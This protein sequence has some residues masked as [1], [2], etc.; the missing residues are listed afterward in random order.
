MTS[1]F[2]I[3]WD[4]PR[5]VRFSVYWL[6]PLLLSTAILLMAGELGSSSRFTLPILRYLLPSYSN[7]ELA[8]LNLLVRKVG[9]FLAYA[10]LS[11]T[12][13]RAWRWHMKLTS[14]K[15]VFLALTI[16]LFVSM[17]DESWQTLYLSRSGR[18]QDVVLDMSGALTATIALFPFLKQDDKRPNI[19]V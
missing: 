4:R 19:S 14:L 9:H 6:P 2:S 5:L 7:S 1:N 16:C 3:F 12:Y 17:A 11:Y 13:A 8:H 15:S 18:P 10:L